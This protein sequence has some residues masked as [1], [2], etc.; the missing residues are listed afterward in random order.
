MPVII[1]FY[2]AL[3]IATCRMHGSEK[4]R[5]RYAFFK[6]LTSLCFVAIAL[7]A[8]FKSGF[9][10]LFFYLLPGFWF[11]VAGDYLLGLAHTDRNYKGKRFLLGAAGRRAFAER[12][13]ARARRRRARAI[14][15]A[16]DLW[17]EL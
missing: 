9:Q 14:S 3:V 1:A 12:S 11:A 16:Q 15:V 4:F 17:R 7:F 8:G 10:P 5:V 13:G 6:L 2:G